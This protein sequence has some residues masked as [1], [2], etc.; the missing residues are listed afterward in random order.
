MVMLPVN[1][2]GRFEGYC[3]DMALFG[4]NSA[5][6]DV[7]LIKKFLCKELCEHRQQPNF[8]VKKGGTYSCIKTEYLKFMGILQ[9]LAPGYNLKSFFKAFGV[10]EQNDFFH[11]TTLH[12]QIN[13]MKPLY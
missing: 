4:F 2:F 11:M 5:G 9:F 8:T 13:W 6:Y 10:S 1:L 3:K 7:K 12:M